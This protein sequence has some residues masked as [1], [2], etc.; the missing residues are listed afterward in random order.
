MLYKKINYS[1]SYSYQQQKRKESTPHCANK[2]IYF[3]ISKPRLT[4]ST[5]ILPTI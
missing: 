2:A 4:M 3:L 1:E 5:D